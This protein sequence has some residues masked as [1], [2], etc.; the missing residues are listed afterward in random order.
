[1]GGDDAPGPRRAEGPGERPWTDRGQ[2]VAVRMGKGTGWAVRLPHSGRRHARPLKSG[3][4]SGRVIRPIVSEGR[5]IH[6]RPRVETGKGGASGLRRLLSRSLNAKKTR[7]RR[8]AG[9]LPY[10][11]FMTLS[12]SWQTEMSSTK[13]LRNA[14]RGGRECSAKTLVLE[15]NLGHERMLARVSLR[16]P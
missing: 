16:I 13:W 12:Y 15:A 10:S 7:Q 3:L 2:L 9:T 6:Q 8:Q 14:S 11:A 5:Q 1:M 4:G